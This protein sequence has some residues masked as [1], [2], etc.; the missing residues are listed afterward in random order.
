LHITLRKTEKVKEF[1]T[2]PGIKP[3]INFSD[4]LLHNIS[5]K[6][7]ELGSLFGVFAADCM[8]LSIGGQFLP[9]GIGL[10]NFSERFCVG[11]AVKGG[12]A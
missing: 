7:L 8:E 1:K 6:G 2:L 10:Q 3:L 4:Y 9:L 5:R 12:R 11:H